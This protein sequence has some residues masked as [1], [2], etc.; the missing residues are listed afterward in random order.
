M[1]LSVISYIL[2][3]LVPFHSQI[4]L[5]GLGCFVV[6]EK[7]SQIINYGTVIT[8]PRKSLRFSFSIGNND[9]LIE[10][11]YAKL[12]NE[13]THDAK[14]NVEK[15]IRKIKE[16]L[17]QNRKVKLPQLGE[18]KF[19]ENG[20]LL[21]I[22]SNDISI[23]P[24]ASQPSVVNIVPKESI[25]FTQAPMEIPS[26]PE[27]DNLSMQRIL[28]YVLEASV[29]S[30]GCREDIAAAIQAKEQVEMFAQ[31]DSKTASL[32]EPAD[33]QEI[34]EP[35]DTHEPDSEIKAEPKAN[36]EVKDDNN[37]GTEIESSK[38]K[39][40]K[41]QLWLAI[42][43]IVIIIII[44]FLTIVFV[45]QDELKP[46]LEKILYNSRERALIHHFNL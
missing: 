4:S 19:N 37:P 8:P 10:S 35:T 23:F 32:H 30:R 15:L 27:F 14:L 43:L 24:A 1:D 25:E 39:V 20:E 38:P 33:A 42:A 40:S 45:M 31:T 36:V 13:N 11:E 12:K 18:L 17:T 44:L 16:Q 7:P 29:I 41:K 21:F 28:N 22:P 5:P 2:K 34:K 26:A 46:F 6:D 9:G 3:E